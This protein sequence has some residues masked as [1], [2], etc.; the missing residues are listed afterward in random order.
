M[1]DPSLDGVE[2]KS[3]SN[4]SICTHTCIF[5]HIHIHTYT[6]LCNDSANTPST[7]NVQ[8]YSPSTAFFLRNYLSQ[9][10]CHMPHAPPPLLSTRTHS[11]THTHTHTRTHTPPQHLHTHTHTHIHPHTHPHTRTP[12]HRNVYLSPARPNVFLWYF[13]MSVELPASATAAACLTVFRILH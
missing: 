4:F 7:H 12:T 1:E 3:D 13:N 9:C 10:T 8:T 5:T 11:D 2:R 6:H